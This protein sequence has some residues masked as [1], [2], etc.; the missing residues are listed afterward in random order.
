MVLCHSGLSTLVHQ[1]MCDPEVGGWLVHGAG[2]GGVGQRA[3]IGRH[4]GSGSPER[5][6]CLQLE[7]GD[8]LGEYC[9]N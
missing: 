2:E 1:V 4:T 5:G 9:N 7:K 3:C 8:L 6:G